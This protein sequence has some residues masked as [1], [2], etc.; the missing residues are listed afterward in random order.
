M[1]EWTDSKPNK[2]FCIDLI[3]L[4]LSNAWLQVVCL[5]FKW[6]HDQSA[7]CLLLS[8]ISCKFSLARDI[9][10]T[11]EI[12]LSFLAVLERGRNYQT[13]KWSIWRLWKAGWHQQIPVN[14]LMNRNPGLD[15]NLFASQQPHCCMLPGRAWCILYKI[16]SIP[17]H[18]VQLVRE[19]TFTIY[20]NKMFTNPLVKQGFCK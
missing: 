5:H 4:I 14:L 7:K 11:Q 17:Y 18:E 9:K 3:L 12:F 2:T 1:D 6:L 15:K 16:F 20:P 19:A 13:S 8:I 10:K